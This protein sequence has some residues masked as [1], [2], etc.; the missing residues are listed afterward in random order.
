VKT[1][2]REPLVHF[3]ALGALLFVLNGMFGS[4]APVDPT[5]T[6]SEPEIARLLQLFSA[7]WQRPPTRAELDGL[8]EQ[9]IREEVLY[10]EAVA[11]GLDQND[12]IVRRRLVQKLE[13]LSQDLVDE[14]PSEADLR[15][16]FE[17]NAARF[18]EPAMLTFTHVYLNPD[19]RGDSMRADAERLLTGLRAGT[20]GDT[21]ELG[22][23]FL[24][25]LSFAGRSQREVA[26]LFGADFA[27]DLATLEIGSWQGPIGSGYGAHL[28]LVQQRVDAHVPEFGSVR[29]KVRTEYLSVQRR[30]ADETM[31]RQ[32][33]G[34]YRIEVLWPAEIEA[35]SEAA[36]RSE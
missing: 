2:L 13:F 36:E 17:D 21:A 11:L 12:T 5:I 7:Q 16:F 10:R 33:R 20:A 6:V 8:V 26:G 9:Q 22:D 15:A 31:Y 28:V 35:A 4:S 29:D 27:A 32:L 24:L 1:W 3:L 30:D 25:P 23:T 14:N 34:R 19:G 18:E